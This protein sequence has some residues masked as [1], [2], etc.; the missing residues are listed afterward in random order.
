MCLVRDVSLIVFQDGQ[1]EQKDA[2][3]SRSRAEYKSIEFSVSSYG[4]TSL[5]FVSVCSLFAS[6]GEGMGEGSY[7]LCVGPFS[8]ME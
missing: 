6:F 7:S 5:A 2:C 3:H 8:V 4:L 1:R